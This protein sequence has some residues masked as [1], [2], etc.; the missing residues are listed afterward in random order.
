MS[1]SLEKTKMHE[2]VYVGMS[3]DTRQNSEQKRKCFAWRMANFGVYFTLYVVA[4]ARSYVNDLYNWV[5][6]VKQKFI[7]LVESCSSSF[8]ALRTSSE[9]HNKHNF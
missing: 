2:F 4:F 9:D 6:A 1:C 7:R 3:N 8:H 5:K